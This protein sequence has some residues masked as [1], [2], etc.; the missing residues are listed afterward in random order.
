[1]LAK[2]GKTYTNMT[3]TSIVRN[4]HVNIEF[5]SEI[6]FQPSQNSSVTLPYTRK[7]A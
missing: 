7:L 3:V 5:C 4:M 6:G 2:M 1:M